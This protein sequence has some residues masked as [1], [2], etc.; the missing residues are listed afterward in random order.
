[1]LAHCRY[2]VGTCLVPTCYSSIE[3][4]LIVLS[5]SV[6]R[7]HT[8]QE[9]PQPKLALLFNISK[10]CGWW[11]AG[12]HKNH[13]AHHP[14]C[15]TPD[16]HTNKP[17]PSHLMTHF[18]LNDVVIT[19]YEAPWWIMI[20]IDINSILTLIFI[21]ITYFPFPLQILILYFFPGIIFS[22]DW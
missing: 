4:D 3:E 22:V 5:H 18:V 10:A 15:T 1:M 7:S 11:D 13:P 17:K 12:L 14:A 9:L 19:K 21:W 6:M 2:I 8:Q 16:L 20:I